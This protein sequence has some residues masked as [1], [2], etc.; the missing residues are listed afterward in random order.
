MYTLTHGFID[1]LKIRPDNIYEWRRSADHLLF[2]GEK[3][4]GHRGDIVIIPEMV[5]IPAPGDKGKR[6]RYTVC[7]YYHIVR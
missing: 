2:R 1:I 6:W 7:N 5:P 4:G 3:G